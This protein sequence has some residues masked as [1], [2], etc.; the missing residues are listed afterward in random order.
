MNTCTPMLL[1]AEARAAGAILS[2]VRAAAASALLL[3]AANLCGPNA[4]VWAQPAAP[5]APDNTACL[6]CHDDKTAVAE[7]KDGARVSIHLDAARHGAGVHGR[8]GKRCVDCHTG[9]DLDRHPDRELTDRRAYARS[10]SALCARCHESQA[11]A[12]AAD[13]HALS[14]KP[15]A[16]VCTDCHDPHYESARPRRLGVA[17][18]C[19]RC[20]VE[21]L[22]RYSRGAHGAALLGGDNPD[23]PVCTDCHAAHGAHAVDKTA[24]RLAAAGLCGRCHG[25]AARMEPYRLSPA[26]MQ[27]YL[28]DF[29][30]ITLSYSRKNGASTGPLTS[31][32][33]DCHGAHDIARRGSP[34]SLHVKGNLAKACRSCHPEATE[35][36]SDAWLSHYIPSP[37]RAPLVFFV[38]LAYWIFIP[39]VIG[40]LGILVVVD[41]RQAWRR[42]RAPRPAPVPAAPPAERPVRRFTPLRRL[43]HLVVMVTFTL[44]VLTGVPQKFADT[45]WGEFLIVTCGGMDATRLI[46]RVSGVLFA[47]AAAL[48]LLVNLV[49][50]HRGRIAPDMLV[51][52]RDFTH[53]VDAVRAAISDAAAPA[54]P[55]ADRYDFRQ[56]FEYWGMLAGS[57]VMIASG[58]ILYFPTLLARFLPGQ[59]I[60]AAKVAHSSE[61]MLAL[62]T[63]VVWHLYCAHLKPGLFPGDF[64]IFSGRLSR[65]RMRAE[66]PLELER[67]EAA[68]RARAG[69]GAARDERSAGGADGKGG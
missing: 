14:G 10:S 42:R 20:H 66:H 16:A 26:V 60:P 52:R 12:F 24:A 30:G 37:T 49:L 51:G 58:F 44:L 3:L 57:S 48:H 68:E 64:S 38:K 25:D 45:G 53:A 61:A 63:I 9:F 19:G 31:T 35:S 40:G 46:H 4:S 23:V 41:L 34:A 15:E 27:T 11:A 28:Q 1:R 21:A 62:L 32:C 67:I 29:H 39:F 33:I 50:L 36:F 13:V 2:R 56:K 18:A 59:V 43:E 6:E 69:E 65:E 47:V 8:A 54:E 22:A 5:A 17:E 7:F 55:R